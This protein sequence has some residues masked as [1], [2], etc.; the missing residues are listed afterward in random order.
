MDISS[1]FVPTLRVIFLVIHGGQLAW[2]IKNQ[3]SPGSIILVMGLLCKG[4]GKRKYVMVHPAVRLKMLVPVK[5][6]G[7]F[8][9]GRI[10]FHFLINTD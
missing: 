2:F 3:V 4:A 5:V 8:L 7:I 6:P 1:L 9:A 10:F